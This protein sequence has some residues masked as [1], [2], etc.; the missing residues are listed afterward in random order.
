MKRLSLILSTVL[1]VALLDTSSPRAEV[2]KWVDK[3]GTVHYT[4]DPD[5]L[6]EP[7]RSKVLRQLEEKL[8]RRKKQEKRPGRRRRR[9]GLPNEKLPPPPDSSRSESPRTDEP[10]AFDE[11]AELAKQR[12]DWSSRAT[13]A[14]EQV[15]RIEK[16][17]EELRSKRDQS[18]RDALILARPADREKAQKTADAL[19]SCE[20]KLGK[21]RHYLD[22]EL[23]EQ[24]RRAG[25]PPGWLR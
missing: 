14:R 19:K 20:E 11:A 25:I 15:S 1:A 23:P 17:C 4:D 13:R 10:D 2:Y 18:K 6:P 12:K 21:A 16:E 9:D 5:Q 7:M 8:N 22:V 24:A 3:K